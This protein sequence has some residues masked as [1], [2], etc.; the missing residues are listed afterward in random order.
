MFRRAHEPRAGL[1]GDARHGPLLEGR[2]Q[3]VLGKFLRQADVAHDMCQAGDQ[4]G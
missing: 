1:G 3:G 2:D 4:P